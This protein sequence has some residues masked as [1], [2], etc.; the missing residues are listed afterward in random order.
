MVVQFVK[1]VTKRERQL[2]FLCISYMNRSG[3]KLSLMTYGPNVRG[4]KELCTKMLY[5][6]TETAPFS[7]GEG[8]L[9]RI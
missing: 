4:V 3:Y 6:A 1:R 7:I 9:K 5:A 8:R 2:R